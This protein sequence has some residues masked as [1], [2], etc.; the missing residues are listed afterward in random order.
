MVDLGDEGGGGRV[1]G[2]VGRIVKDGS[3]RRDQV[4][5][6][7][8]LVR[9]HKTM[10]S[11]PSSIF[12]LIL[13][14]HRL[15]Y[16]KEMT[17]APDKLAFRST[18]LSFLKEERSRVIKE[19]SKEVDE[20]YKNREKR[21]SEKDKIQEKYQLPTLQLIPLASQ[22]SVEEFVERYETLKRI[23]ITYRETNDENPMGKFFSQL[24][25]DKEALGGDSASVVH[26]AK[27]GLDKE[28]AVERITAAAA[29]GI[30][31]VTLSGVDEGGDTL[32]GNNENFQIKKPIDDLDGDPAVAAEKMYDSFSELVRDGVINLDRQAAKV[33]RKIASIF[34]GYFE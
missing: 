12:L 6:D 18:L 26:V 1:L 30:N 28:A 5:K 11:S 24:R 33:T 29:E 14:S 4:Y 23:K 17:G 7:G 21:K 27:E 15:V 13:N 31:G 34:M 19:K 25:K 32:V 20:K 2:I 22:S 16:V 9:D 8:E 10:Q 3:L